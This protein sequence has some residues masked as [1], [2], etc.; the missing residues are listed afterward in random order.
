MKIT[1]KDCGI[2]LQGRG[3]TGKCLSCS[4]KGLK[5]SA[6]VRRQISRKLKGHKMSVETRKKISEAKNGHEVPSEVRRKISE[7]KKGTRPWNKGRH[8]R[9]H[10]D[11]HSGRYPRTKKNTTANEAAV[12]QE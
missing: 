1:C 7:S 11:R 2:E 4:H 10:P 3:K 8:Y 5:R 12:P 6:K 9:Q